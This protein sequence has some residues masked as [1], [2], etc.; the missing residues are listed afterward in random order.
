M[1][2][3]PTRW[4]DEESRGRGAE[5]TEPLPRPRSL[6]GDG[7]T[8][9][10]ENGALGELHTLPFLGV[11]KMHAAGGK[12]W[13]VS[14]SIGKFGPASPHAGSLGVRL[15]GQYLSSVWAPASTLLSSAHSVGFALGF[16]L[17]AVPFHKT[18]DGPTG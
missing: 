15:L 4:L 6:S 10:F 12:G 16:W 14:R 3:S 18:P 11:I 7:M 9:V 13:G 1:V 5:P 8:E 17:R 2:S